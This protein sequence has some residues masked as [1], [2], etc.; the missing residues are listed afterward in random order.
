MSN[1]VNL[2]RIIIIALAIISITLGVIYG[3]P[4]IVLRKAT[5]ICMECIGLG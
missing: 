5:K 1:K 2:S 3:E 4:E